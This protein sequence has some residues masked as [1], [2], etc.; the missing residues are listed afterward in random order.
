M[1]FR[2]WFS[3]LLA[4]FLPLSVVFLWGI[5]FISS[6][7]DQNQKFY[8]QESLSQQ[9][10]LYSQILDTQL[11]TLESNIEQSLALGSINQASPFTMLMLVDKLENQI[12]QVYTDKGK[13]LTKVEM[14][15]F[16]KAY[17]SKIQKPTTKNIFYF[18]VLNFNSH[19]TK[20]DKIYTFSLDKP[21]MISD[22]VM[23]GLVNKKPTD[24]VLKNKISKKKKSKN[25]HISRSK[26]NPTKTTQNIGDKIIKENLYIIGL[27]KAD[28]FLTL[29]KFMHLKSQT[30]R[31]VFLSNPE[32]KILFH[33]QQEHVFKKLSDSSSVRKSIEGFDSN[34]QGFTKNYKSN[35]NNFLKR[36]KKSQQDGLASESNN[37]VES[38]KKDRLESLAYVQK[39]K[40]SNL[41]LVSK[42]PWLTHSV[43][44]SEWAFMWMFFCFLIVALIFIGFIFAVRPLYLAYGYLKYFFI[45][46]AKTGDFPSWSQELKNPY[47]QFYRNRIDNMKLQVNRFTQNKDH[48]EVAPQGVTFSRLLKEE[49]ES[50]KIKFPN[51]YVTQNIDSDIKLFGFEDSMRLVLHQLL[52][53]AIES[54]GAKD[55]QDI[56]LSCKTKD[57]NFVFSI[58]DSGI[59]IEEKDYAKAFQMYYSTKSQLGVGLNLV[60]TIVQSQE[61][62]IEMRPTENNGLEIIVSL[63]EKCFIKSYRQTLSKSSSGLQNNFSSHSNS[64]NRSLK[65]ED[66]D[67]SVRTT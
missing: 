6:Y 52:L 45:Y 61:G 53:N 63:P 47:L 41:F 43:I 35:N 28:K 33:N 17:M 1:R 16:S 54:M 51:S 2:F 24:Q 25:S 12:V 50:L 64:S 26:N 22:N 32:G 8:L 36:D 13:D 38:Y 5:D 30:G 65:K 29:L 57:N 48:S 18:G 42:A 66:T 60:Q 21:K 19:K 56:I 55:K 14:Q 4:V 7:K 37:F 20:K 10:S 39:L 27:V 23:L 3:L 59:G 40:T 44:N 11:A 31:E 49:V 15:A 67:R 9:Q 58:K 62:F 46:F 34:H